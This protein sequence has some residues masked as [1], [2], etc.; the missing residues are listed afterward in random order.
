VAGSSAPLPA[1]ARDP[2]WIRVQ[3]AYFDGVRVVQRL[4]LKYVDWSLPVACGPWA[5]IDLAGHVLTVARSYHRLLDAALAGEARS[6]LARGDDL[7]DCGAV[8][9]APLTVSGGVDRIVA[10]DA[11]ATRYGERVGDLDPD[12]VLGAWREVGDL[13]LRQHTTLAAA[14]WH[15]HAWDLAGALGWDYRPADPEVLLEGRRALPEPVPAGAPWPAV[16]AASGRHD[17]PP[18][19]PIGP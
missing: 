3:R 19:R 1:P 5:A 11:V 16:L 12:L 8:E 4:G 14:E 18:G 2:E 13:T 9:A 15:L 17:P 7:A 10:F 6:G